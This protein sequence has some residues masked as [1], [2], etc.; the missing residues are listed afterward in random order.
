[1]NVIYGYN[2]ILTIGDKVQIKR[3]DHISTIS[4]VVQLP[5]CYVYRLSEP[6][7]EYNWHFRIYINKL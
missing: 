5:H 3:T 6:H 2:D 1:M 7:W 4:E